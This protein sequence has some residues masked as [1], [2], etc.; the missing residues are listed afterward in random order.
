LTPLPPL[1]AISQ[2]RRRDDLAN[3]LEPSRPLAVISQWRRRDEQ[4]QAAIQAMNGT[5]LDG[6]PLRVNEAA[7]QLT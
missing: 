4:A 7:H 2:W 6:R 5:D 1:T 3:W